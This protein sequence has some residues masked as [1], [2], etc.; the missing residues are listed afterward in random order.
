MDFSDNDS[1]MY[2]KFRLS[3][4]NR[5]HALKWPMQLHAE[6]EHM[7]LHPDSNHASQ[8]DFF[9]T[10]ETLRGIKLDILPT[11]KVLCRILLPKLHGM[12]VE[13]LNVDT[14]KS[15]LFNQDTL[16]PLFVVVVFFVPMQ[17]KCLNWDTSLIRTPL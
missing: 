12:L 2:L 10:R 16:L 9:W 1:T 14:L 15:G 11:C 5:T 6:A 4:R 13:P 3:V 17:W 8:N 7:S